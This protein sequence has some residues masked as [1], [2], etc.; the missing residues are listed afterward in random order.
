[1]LSGVVCWVYGYDLG[2][3]SPPQPELSTR[4]VYV[5]HWLPDLKYCHLSRF[6]TQN[7]FLFFLKTVIR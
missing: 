5:N 2:L 3:L 1:M 6:D 7:I 4:A